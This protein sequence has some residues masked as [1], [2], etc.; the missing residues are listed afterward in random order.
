MEFKES[1]LGFISSVSIWEQDE[2]TE[3]DVDGVERSC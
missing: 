1:G 2:A 3:H